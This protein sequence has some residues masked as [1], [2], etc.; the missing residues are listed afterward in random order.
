MI[1]LFQ[2]VRKDPKLSDTEFRQRW[3][4]YGDELG[5]MGEGMHAVRVVINTTLATEINRN[6]SA[7][8][9]MLP[10][11]DGVAEIYWERGSDLLEATAQAAMQEQIEKLR[12]FQESFTELETSSMFLVSE[13]VVR[14]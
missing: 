2:C 3:K 1:K 4:E 9:G 7:E 13:F 14:G 6:L 12:T 11:Y 10:A 5:K 8:R